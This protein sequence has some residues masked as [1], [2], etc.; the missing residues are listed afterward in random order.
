[1]LAT[2]SSVGILPSAV[3]FANPSSADLTFI[4]LL[5]SLDFNLFSNASVAIG[6]GPIAF[7][8][9]LYFPKS[10]AAHFTIPSN[11]CLEAVYKLWPLCPSKELI[12]PI[13]I[14]DPPDDFINSTECFIV[15]ATP[16]TFTLKTF[17]HSSLSISLMVLHGGTMPALATTTSSF[18][19]FF[20]I[21][22]KPLI[23]S[24]SL[25]TFTC[26]NSHPFKSLLLSCKSNPNPKEL[27]C[28]NFSTILRPNP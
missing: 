16:F 12:D 20:L 21:C 1:M 25:E 10:M 24:S 14:I 2:S 23:I 6:P 28:E 3:L 27:F 17:S 9:M 11:A 22:L 18:P 26:K 4:P 19:I 7:T 13:T 15:R 5:S 8:L